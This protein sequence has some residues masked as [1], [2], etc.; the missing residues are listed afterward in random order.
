[1]PVGEESVLGGEVRG[2]SPAS[3]TGHFRVRT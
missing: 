2:G 1:M 3:S